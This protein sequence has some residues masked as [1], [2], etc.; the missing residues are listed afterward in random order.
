MIRRRARTRSDGK[1]ETWEIETYTASP[2]DDTFLPDVDLRYFR[3]RPPPPGWALD[4][5]EGL[6][7]PIDILGELF[8]EITGETSEDRAAAREAVEFQRAVDVG[9][10]EDEAFAWVELAAAATRILRLPVLHGQDGPEW[11]N[12]IHRLQDALLARPAYRAY[13]AATERTG[14]N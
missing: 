6:T 10:T 2:T 13:L 11:V 4:D 9:M 5:Q 1:R 12:L 14:G 8:F 3:H 7:I